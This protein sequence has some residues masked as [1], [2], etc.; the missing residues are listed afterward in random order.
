MSPS[1]SRT[2]SAVG[3]RLGEGPQD[4]AG[5]LEAL[6]LEGSAGVAQA[7]LGLLDAPARDGLAR[8]WDRTRPRVVGDRAARLATRRR[9]AVRPRPTASCASPRTSPSSIH[10]SGSQGTRPSGVAARN[11]FEAS[12]RP[13]SRMRP[14][15]LRATPPQPASLSLSA[16]ASRRFHGGPSLGRS[17]SS[18]ARGLRARR[19]SLPGAR[20]G[21]GRPRPDEEAG[22]L[23]MGPVK[24]TA[25]TT[26]DPHRW[27]SFARASSAASYSPRASRPKY[28][29]RWR[30]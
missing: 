13:V 1:S 5:L 4:L 26:K 24:P 15:P 3:R 20:T 14:A 8:A 22:G 28:H 25:K 18:A 16:S 7:L 6:P 11:A 9:V 23:A 27:G 21:R 12:P 30:A 17:P 10:S 2:D 19:P 29:R